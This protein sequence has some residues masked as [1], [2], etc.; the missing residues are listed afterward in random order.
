V[1]AG[2]VVRPAPLAPSQL[3]PVAVVVAKHAPSAH[4]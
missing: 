2:Q 4:V 1:P 3:A